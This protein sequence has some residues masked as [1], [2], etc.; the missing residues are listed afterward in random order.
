M[1]PVVLEFAG[2]CKFSK[3]G[4]YKTT[5][6]TVTFELKSETR[7]E[8]QPETESNTHF[9]PS[10]DIEISTDIIAGVNYKINQDKGMTKK[11]STCLL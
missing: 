6:S 5:L 3:L 2:S 10:M 7:F 8:K 4:N 9:S 11:L 1:E